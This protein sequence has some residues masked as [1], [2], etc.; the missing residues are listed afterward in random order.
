MWWCACRCVCINEPSPVIRKCSAVGAGACSVGDAQ[1]ANGAAALACM[2]AKGPCLP[3]SQLLGAPACCPPALTLLRSSPPPWCSGVLFSEALLA[4]SLLLLG[5]LS[6]MMSYCLQNR[7][8]TP[9]GEKALMSTQ[10]LNLQSSV[11]PGGDHS[12]IHACSFL[13]ELL[14]PPAASYTSSLLRWLQGEKLKASGTSALN[15]C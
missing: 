6:L 3:A 15:L 1:A 10:E 13:T 4:F 2:E 12:I 14:S 5:S 11:P 7:A 9:G 8:I